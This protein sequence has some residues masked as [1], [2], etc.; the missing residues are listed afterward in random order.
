M[1]SFIHAEVPL[2]DGLSFWIDGNSKIAW[3]NG[4]YA[5]PKPNALSLPH[6]ATC[7]GSTERCRSSCLDSSHK[8]LTA[9][10]R[11]VPLKDVRPGD[12]LVSF[13]EQ[14]RP[15]ERWRYHRTGTVQAIRFRRADVFAVTLASGKVFRVTDDH[16][17][18]SRKANGTNLR[19]I[20]TRDLRPGKHVAIR[21]QDEWDP[22][23]SYDAGWLA[24]LYDG[25][26]CL[27]LIEG[28]HCCQLTLSQKEGL[29]LD[30]ARRI[31]D[32][33]FGEKAVSH[34]AAERSVWQMRL[35]GGRRP[36]ARVLGSLR[37]VRLLAKFRP[38]MLGVV[39]GR[40][41]DA[42]LSIEPDGQAEI[43]EVDVDAKTM[44]VE[45]YAHHNCYVHGLK[46]QAPEVYAKYELNERS[47]HA[48]LDDS[49]AARS[50]SHILAEWIKENARGGFRWHV[51]GDVMSTN[52]AYW[53]AEVCRAARDV[54]F[55]IYTRTIH[56]VG[57]LRLAKNLAVNVSADVHNASVAV[58][59]A[60]AL[61]VRICYLVSAH[62]EV[63]P[64]LPPGSVIFP[65]YPLRG[66]ELAEPTE[67]PWWQS[68]SLE[69]RRMVCP[70]DFFG[71]SESAR[72]GP[73]TKCLYPA[74]VTT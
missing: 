61:G 49:R 3:A 41:A 68:L 19:W 56:A 39:S 35:A 40:D 74:E 54:P 11:Y 28:Q 2:F 71:Q 42:I 1:T 43:A 30:R 24:G 25:E 22:M 20:E 48:I 36:I 73:C 26:G 55:W 23:T 18:L 37:P 17:W 31:I 15:G 12:Q 46:K 72:C 32:T 62:D 64:D 63:L 10:L 53:I 6:I 66:R 70:A 45:G 59:L 38:E 5:E 21:L 69:R 14:R 29:V 7:P 44:V 9:D 4:T 33:L 13:D 58:P 51:S 60:R 47:I 52:H 65:D 50:A 67:A 27:C 8:V 57:V 34:R 16:R